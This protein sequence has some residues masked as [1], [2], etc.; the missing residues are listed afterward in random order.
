MFERFTE[1]ARRVI[2][3][4]RY[5]AS[6]FGS[7]MIETEHLLL[8]LL[9]EDPLTRLMLPPKAGEAI[10]AIIQK[11]TPVREKT[12]TSV[13]LPLSDPAKRVL[14]YAMEESDQLGHPHI[15][16]EHLLLG[17]LREEGTLACKLLDQFGLKLDA[18]RKKA[19][20]LDKER[21]GEPEP[22][23]TFERPQEK[24]VFSFGADLTE[25]A[26]RYDSSPLIGRDP[27]LE[28]LMRVLC[29]RGRRNAVLVGEPGVGKRALVRGLA[30]RIAGGRVPECLGHRAIVALD[31]P[32]IVAGV[33]SRRLFEES[34]AGMTASLPDLSTPLILFVDELHALA[35]A[36]PACLQAAH[37]LKAAIL[38]GTVQ[39]ISTATPADY[40]KAITGERWLEQLFQTV[41]V[42]TPDQAQALEI[43]RATKDH[44]EQF[45]EVQYTD[46]ALQYA[47]F[48]SHN[49]ILHRNL[50]GKA[51]D[52]IDEAAA[53]VKIRRQ[54]RPQEIVEAQARLRRV[55]LHRKAFM[56]APRFLSNEEKQLREEIKQLY[57]KHGL[58]G[59]ET[60]AVT[61]TDI[62][63]IVS[64]WTGI[65]L[66]AI[67]ASRMP[68]V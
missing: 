15:G 57:E 7:P 23:F 42:E 28:Q 68:G 45:H 31:L 32:V 16:T 41:N 21:S 13:D 8:G 12:S 14:G 51:I 11:E 35:T 67:R 65:P 19:A 34:L 18:A 2:F 38:R 53:Q 48:H 24:S 43:L 17:L 27:E 6:Q 49:Y 26:A 61:R 64:Q 60:D 25:L 46:E 58:A 50:P 10:L 4:G 1:K 30:G 39:C 62:E 20:T 9:R 22:A 3:F 47:V 5:E 54:P 55:S 44:Y 40:Q 29:C 52:L 56:D 66:A 36:K 59:K 37:V 63:E 33:E